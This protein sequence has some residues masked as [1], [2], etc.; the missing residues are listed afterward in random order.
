MSKELS[1]KN[2]KAVNFTIYYEVL[3]PDCKEFI[4]GQVSKAYSLLS[5]IMNLV[6]VPYG[7]AKQT[8]NQTTQ[9]WEFTCQ[10][11]VDECWGNKLHACM[12]GTRPETAEHFPFVYCMEQTKT[13]LKEDIRQVANSCAK[14]LR[15]DISSELECADGPFGM[16]KNNMQSFFILFFLFSFGGNSCDTVMCECSS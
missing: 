16:T 4:S 3:C 1:V 14:Q 11:G 8:L 13:K 7:N 5:E 15:L 10:H 2:D 9:M 12:I 6:L